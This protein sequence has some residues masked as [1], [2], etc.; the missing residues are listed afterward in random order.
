LRSF[1]VFGVGHD[2][3]AHALQEIRARSPGEARAIAER[4]FADCPVIE[5]WEASVLIARLKRA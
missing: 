3:R 5:I 2:G 4:M 1:K